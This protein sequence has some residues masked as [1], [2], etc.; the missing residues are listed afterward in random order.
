MS[1]GDVEDPSAAQADASVSLGG[2]VLRYDV[3][4]A[5]NPDDPATIPADNPFVNS[6]EWCRGLRNTFGLAL[7][8]S[9]GGLFGADNGPARA[10]SSAPFGPAARTG[11]PMS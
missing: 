9:T 10:R 4:D 7:H 6:P 1:I 5:G 2:K 3:L 8:P 11:I